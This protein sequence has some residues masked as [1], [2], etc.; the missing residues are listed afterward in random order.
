MLG[1]GFHPMLSGRENAH[2]GAIVAGFS[3]REARRRLARV[4]EFAELEEHI[5]Q[6]LRTYSDG[7]RARLGFSVAIHTEPEI[8]LL[9]EILAVGDHTFQQK[10]IGRLQQLQAEGVTLVLASHDLAQVRSLCDRTLWLE[11]GKAVALGNSSEVCGRYELL[12][13][14]RVSAQD[15]RATK[16]LEIVQARLLGPG[17][18][19]EINT[20]ETGSSPVVAIDYVVNRPLD[21]AIF[22]VTVHTSPE[23]SVVRHETTSISSDDQELHGSG[24][25][26]LR[27]DKLELPD[28]VYTMSV[29][30]YSP[31]WAHRYDF[32]W[33]AVC[34]EV[35][36]LPLENE[37]RR[38]S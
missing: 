30:T 20:V 15:V 13:E 18:A 31:T 34:F 27:L 32:L 24:T 28:G 16:D 33:D 19:G 12:M 21:G 38:A 37:R 8:L 11:K 6:P 10:C 7:M 25:V 22:G 14:E 9:D 26:R 2:S 1:E 23:G 35:P 29:A 36:Y 4:V 5:D 17:T 3:G